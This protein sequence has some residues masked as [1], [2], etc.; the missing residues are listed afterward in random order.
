MQELN[1]TEYIT[2]LAASLGIDSNGLVKSPEEKQQE[3]EARQKQQQQMMEQQMMSDVASKVAPE[4]AKGEVQN[5]QQQ[6]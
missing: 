3:A 5:Q 6:Q 4:M 1:V 2:R